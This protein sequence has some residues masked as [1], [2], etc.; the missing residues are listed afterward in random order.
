MLPLDVPQSQD[1]LPLPL[2]RSVPKVSPPALLPL[3][4]VLPRLLSPVSQL[5]VPVSLRPPAALRTVSRVAPGLRAAPSMPL[6]P[7]RTPPGLIGRLVQPLHARRHELALVLGQPL[8][9]P[10]HALA[11]LQDGL[12]ARALG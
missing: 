5:D 4:G 8:A 11:R 12:T 10:G 6:D 7:H 9:A 2:P 3:P 1:T